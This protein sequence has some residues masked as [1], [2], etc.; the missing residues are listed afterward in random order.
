[1][2][3]STYKLYEYILKL[4]ASEREDEA[5]AFRAIVSKY[6]K[7]FTAVLK[8]L[9]RKQRG[10]VST[11]LNPN[12]DYVDFYMF[13]ISAWN[14]IFENTISPYIKDAAGENGKRV[15]EDLPIEKG[16]KD[17][18]VG[19]DFNMEYPEA[20]AKLEAQAIKF[21][22]ATNETTEIAVREA[23]IS[24]FSE[25]LA[26]PEITKRVDAVFDYADKVR[27]QMIAQT[28]MARAANYG[29]ISAYKQSGVVE[30]KEWL[31]AEDEKVCPHC[32]DM[33]NQVE[34]L[35]TAFFNLGVA[36]TVQLEDGSEL[37]SENNYLAVEA[38]PL[39]PRC[40]C[41]ILPVIKEL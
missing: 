25:G 2:L 33:D 27:S 38:A 24:G 35:N 23:I 18:V 3:D 10:E 28:E 19:A 1:V 11:K 13:D 4:E 39:H 40:R 21:S 16:F 6:E 14:I 29:A 26:I 22:I 36:Q 30:G 34:D 9:F 32:N 20:I 8:G 7:K 31:T 15:Y 12:K 41:T 5:Q 17:I 37:R